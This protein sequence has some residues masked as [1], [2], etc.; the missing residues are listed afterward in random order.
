MKSSGFT[1]VELV[2]VLVVVGILSVTAM[3]LFA[4]RADFSASLAKDQFIASLLTAQQRALAH[5]SSSPVLFT[6]LQS[7]DGSDWILTVSQGTESFT[8]KTIE[9][10]GAVLQIGGVTLAD[11]GN[12]VVS[13]S[14]SGET[15]EGSDLTWR[16]TGESTHQFCLGEAGFAYSGACVP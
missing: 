1:L 11:G 16:F 15:L 13:F 10:A 8:E 7:A 4:S 14:G 5:H 9:R 3:G 6:V 12:R 2:I